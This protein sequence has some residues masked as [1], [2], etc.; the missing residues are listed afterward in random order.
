M[1]TCSTPRIAP[2]LSRVTN[3]AVVLAAIGV[4]V[5]VSS[6]GAGVRL[7]AGTLVVMGGNSNPTSEGME[8][9]LGGSPLPP[10]TPNNTGFP[11][12][13]P[14]KGYL[15]PSNPDSPYFGYSYQRVNW[16]SQIPLTTGWDGA[17]DF[18]ES[19][20]GGLAALQSSMDAALLT[21]EPVT[22]FGYSSSANVVVREMRRLAAIGSP[23]TD[24]L[25]F[26]MV[27]GMNRPNGGLAQRFPGLFIPLFNIK[28]DG[29][30]PS[31]TQYETLDISWEYDTISDFPN[32]PLNLLSTLNALLGFTLHVNYL[33]AGLDGPRARPDYKDPDSNITYVT[34]AAPYLPMLLPLRLLGVPKQLIDLVEPALKVLIDLGYNR[35]ISPGT[36]TPATLFPAPQQL[37]ALPF[38]LLNAI[39]TGIRRALNPRWDE[40]TTLTPEVDA[41][42]TAAP[43]SGS[44]DNAANL[45]LAATTADVGDSRADFG[46]GTGTLGNEGNEGN[47]GNDEIVETSTEFTKGNAE[48]TE[49]TE[50]RETVEQSPTDL[51]ARADLESPAVTSITARQRTREAGVSPGA[52][53]SSESADAAP[54]GA[55]GTAENISGQP[56]AGGADSDA[57]AG[58]TDSDDKAA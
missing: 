23:A 35:S 10:G 5:F 18:E 37:L 43:L 41:G 12:G 20:L 47:E 58:G 27:A 32:H 50:E 13:V 14:G 57:A 38:D 33:P 45:R 34:L 19:Q 51:P 21:G 36:P 22:V 24:K 11:A 44:E 48:S 42:P 55:A 8:H 25:T 49:V 28:L 40:V 2:C 56:A 54:A 29:S 9:G 16:P 39:G 53:S 52:E 31:D 46:A 4:L 17:T 6:I 30:T 15:D 1:R 3:M 26:I 7:M